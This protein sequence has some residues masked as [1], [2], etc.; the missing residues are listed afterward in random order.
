VM[1]EALFEGRAPWL[2]SAMMS[3]GHDAAFS[4]NRGRTGHITWATAGGPPI[5][6]L[7]LHG[8]TDSG[9]CWRPLVP[10]LAARW[11]LLALDARGHGG[12]A[13]P[14]E[15]F[16]SVA[17]AADAAM[18]LA[19]VADNLRPGGVI[20]V[21]HSMGARTAAALAATGNEYVRAIVLEDPPP[22][23]RPGT[24]AGTVGQSGQLSTEQG[25]RPQP[26]TQAQPGTQRQPHP[27]LDWLPAVRELDL[28]SRLAQS[29]SENPGWPDAEHQP[30]AVSKDQVDM[31]LFEL[32][33]QGMAPLPEVLAD[34]RC[35]VL[36]IRGDAD[37]GSLVTADMAA[38]CAGAAGGEFE[39][40][41]ISG[42]GHSV[43]RDQQQA[44]LAALTRFVEKNL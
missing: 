26:G 11:G 14:E 36:L 18:V 44:Y 29:R 5:D 23:P 2:R 19:A 17:H 27:F 37:R 41:H 24:V 38:Q 25:R 1:V 35:P 10:A 16:G 4:G 30:W 39:V 40:V 28:A 8:F 9:G 32:P 12:S 33:Q 15:P 22:G 20:V 42:A 43:R 13:L 3:T 21:G 34:V 7:F 6:I 31:H